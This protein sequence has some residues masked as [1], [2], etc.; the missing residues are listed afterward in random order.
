MKVEDARRV[1]QEAKVK[2][3]EQVEQEGQ[4]ALRT[5]EKLIINAAKMREEE[6]T[7][8]SK[9]TQFSQDA[10]FYALNILQQNGFNTAWTVEVCGPEG[11]NDYNYSVSWF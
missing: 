5:L 1:T 3:A 9:T 2:Y 6:I 8:T 11:N 7:F 10:C 4:E